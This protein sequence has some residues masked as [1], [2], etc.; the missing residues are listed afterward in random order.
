[1]D[2]VSPCGLTRGIMMKESWYVEV[3][4]VPEDFGLKRVPIADLS[5]ADA[6]TSADMIR[7]AFTSPD[8]YPS[9]TNAILINS[10]AAILL[11]TTYGFKTAIEIVTETLKKGEA[12][13]Q[14]ERIVGW[15]KNNAA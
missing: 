8:D 7:K 15:M 12:L 3:E 9:I 4:F 6:E 14:L 2:E 5:A 10:A 1:M 11:L 13:K